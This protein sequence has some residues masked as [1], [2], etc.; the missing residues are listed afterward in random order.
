MCDASAGSRWLPVGDQGLE[1]LALDVLHNEERRLAILPG[2][3]ERIVD[4]RHAVVPDRAE[5]GGL[6]VEQLEGLPAVHLAGVEHLD[7]HL[8][9]GLVIH[10]QERAAGQSLETDLLVRRYVDRT[11]LHGTVTVTV[12]PTGRYRVDPDR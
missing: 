8:V 2:R 9:R 7:G 4:G 6:A 3:L 1:R 5:H 12:D 11:D 10:R